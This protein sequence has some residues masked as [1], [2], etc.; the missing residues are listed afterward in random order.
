MLLNIVLRHKGQA[1][2]G[3]RWDPHLLELLLSVSL[4]RKG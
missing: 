3:R 4:N 1:V 2:E